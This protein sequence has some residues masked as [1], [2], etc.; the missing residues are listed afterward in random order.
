[1]MNSST[2]QFRTSDGNDM[3][4]LSRTHFPNNDCWKQ[5]HINCDRHVNGIHHSDTH[6]RQ[7]V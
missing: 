5:I 1:M 7:K 3:Y 4:G 2:L 6:S